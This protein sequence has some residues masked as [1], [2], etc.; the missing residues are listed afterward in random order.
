MRAPGNAIDLTPDS[1]AVVR[2]RFAE[3]PSGMGRILW[4]A[5]P[6][7]VMM[8][9]LQAC[10][11]SATDK[12][13]EPRSAPIAAPA[14]IRLV[15]VATHASDGCCRVFTVNP[16]Q[17]DAKV[18]CTLLVLDPAGRVVYS[19]C[20]PGSPPGHRRPSGFD[21]PPGRHGHGVLRLS[22]DLAHDSYTAPCRPAAWHG[23]TAI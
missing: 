13:S 1:F 14:G 6:C 15:L 20:I 10:D 9:V 4:W 17:A 3:D 16:G 22:I 19:G 5:L 21:A 7:L 18:I 11:P 2:S 8:S 23:G 12:A